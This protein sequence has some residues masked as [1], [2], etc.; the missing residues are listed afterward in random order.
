MAKSKA[1]IFFAVSCLKHGNNT[2]KNVPNFKELKV[3]QVM[4]RGQ[5]KKAGCPYCK[6]E[7]RA[8]IGVGAG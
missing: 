2:P 6:A 1:K 7:A 5:A 4:S 8:N 3:G